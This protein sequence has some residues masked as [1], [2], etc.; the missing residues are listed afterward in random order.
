MTPLL[1]LT[2]V[3]KSFGGVRALKGVSF[4]LLPGEVHAIVGENG[5]GKSTLIKTITGA[6]RPDA[7]TIEIAGRTVDRLDPSL[8][9][10][11]GVAVIYQQP[12]LFPDLTVA[13]NIGLRLERGGP[14]RVLRWG[15]RRRRAADLLARV[16]ADVSPDALVRDLS[17]PQQQMVEIAAA[18]GGDA[19]VLILDEP[20]ASLSDREVANLFR[21]VRE[22]K[23]AGVGLA[24]ISHRLEELPQIAD[25][26]T[27]LRD[28][29]YVG[30]QPMAGVDRAALIRMMVGRELSS[31]FPKSKAEWRAKARLGDVALETFDLGCSATG[32][33]GVTLGV[34]SGEIL[35]LAG[36]VGAGRTELARVLFG[37]T[38]ADSGRILMQS[39]E[40]TVRSPSDAVRLGIAYVPE[41]R[42]RHGVVLDLPVAANATLAVLRQVATG[43]LIRFKQER[44]IAAGFVKRLG[45]K[46]P[47]LDT[48]VG[49]LSGGNQQKVALA[50]WLAADPRVLILDEP[51]QGVDVGAKAEIHKL[52]GELAAKGLAII[53]ISSELPEVLGMSDRVMVMHA[54]EVVGT[55][56]RGEATQEKVMEMALGHTP[57]DAVPA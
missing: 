8:A 16:G 10:R 35:G 23:A 42:R 40:V 45:I 7:G 32:V 22:L 18:L 38:P 49:H 47:S 2:D 43:G 33:R 36:L 3:T 52:M 30:T 37:L 24:Y 9:R 57:A 13:E 26:V 50:R 11:L 44:R 34:R 6:H 15:D 39:G 21:V 55:L 48:P 5:A 27:V 54:G 25:R 41:D 28:G 1:R 56:A 51:T 20:T 29:A 53:M 14:W 17:M 12:A 46:T 19:K 31:V 4:E